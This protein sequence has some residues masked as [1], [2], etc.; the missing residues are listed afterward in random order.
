MLVLSRKVNQKII[1]GDGL[2]VL[3][4]VDIRG[5]GVRGENVRVGIEAPKDIS[6]HRHEVFEAIER[7]KQ[8]GLEAEDGHGSAVELVSETSLSKGR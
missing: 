7:L 3:T 1:I 8:E 5:H 2:I 4:I 6:V